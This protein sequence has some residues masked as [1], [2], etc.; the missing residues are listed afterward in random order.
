M[1]GP[2]SIKDVMTAFRQRHGHCDSLAG[3]TLAR[4]VI[5]DM[6]RA[7]VLDR[8]ESVEGFLVVW[9]AKIEK[10]ARSL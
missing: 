3:R 8:T 7:G 6:E 9:Q 5:A 1:S 10:V 2:F 4:A